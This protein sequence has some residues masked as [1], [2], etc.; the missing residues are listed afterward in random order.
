MTEPGV[1]RRA[2]YRSERVGRKR[3]GGVEAFASEIWKSGWASLVL[4]EVVAATFEDGG[5]GVTTSSRHC[6]VLD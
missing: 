3:E 2:L 5:V 6:G 1:G 4:G